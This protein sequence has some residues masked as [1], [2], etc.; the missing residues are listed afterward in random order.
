V[1]GCG[2]WCCGVCLTGAASVRGQVT[3]TLTVGWG[4][5]WHRSSC[6]GIVLMQGRGGGI[7][8]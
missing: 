4:S 8:Q 2:V 6:S 3:M 7:S 5:I 1:T